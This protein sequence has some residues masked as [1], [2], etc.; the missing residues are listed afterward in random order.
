MS[1]A[2]A[3]I[4]FSPFIPTVVAAMLITN[5]LVYLIPPARRAMDSEDRAFPG[6]EYGTAQKTLIRVVIITAP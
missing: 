3:L 5:F 1:G 4:V 6:T 2:T